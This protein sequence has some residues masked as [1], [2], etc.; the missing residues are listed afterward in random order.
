ML[1]T[2]KA[3]LAIASLLTVTATAMAAPSSHRA[4]RMDARTATTSA[5]YNVR[6]Q[7]SGLHYDPS[8]GA[9]EPSFGG[10]N[11]TVFE[12]AKGNID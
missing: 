6:A 5:N 2:T 7:A 4:H 3:M 9:F 12:R 11:Q 1:K 8:T 10:D